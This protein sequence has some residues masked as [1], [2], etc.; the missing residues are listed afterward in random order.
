MDQNFLNFMQVLGK[1]GKF[2][3]W[4]PPLG[5]ALPPTE[6]PRSAPVSVAD[7][8]ER[9]PRLYSNRSESLCAAP[10]SA[11]LQLLDPSLIILRETTRMSSKFPVAC[12]TLSHLSPW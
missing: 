7:C 1:S 5:L 8:G 9:D 10:V 12:L 6:N 3:C 2:V 11:G 4:R